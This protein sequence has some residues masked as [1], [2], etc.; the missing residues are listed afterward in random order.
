MPRLDNSQSSIPIHPCISTNKPATFLSNFHSKSTNPLRGRHTQVLL[1]TCALCLQMNDAQAMRH[2]RD[3]RV[4]PNSMLRCSVALHLTECAVLMGWVDLPTACKQEKPLEVAH[5]LLLHHAAHIA[6]AASH[7]QARVHS[8]GGGRL[9]GGSM[10]TVAF[11]TVRHQTS[12]VVPA[13]DGS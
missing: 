6:H 12:M 7:L 2:L 13:L 10:L 1:C 11:A 3:T 8:G 5:L 9:T 4:R